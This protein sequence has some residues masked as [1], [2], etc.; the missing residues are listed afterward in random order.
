MSLLSENS[1]DLP[2]PMI[3]INLDR[4]SERFKTFLAR[5]G[6]IGN[7]I[8]HSAT[9]GHAL[10]RAALQRTGYISEN[11]SYGNGTLACALSHIHL[12]ERV[13]AT[14]TP[15]TIFEDDAVLS[16]RFQQLSC[17]IIEK[18]PTNWDIIHWGNSIRPSFVWVDLAQTASRIEP[19][20]PSR[21]TNRDA[22][23]DVFQKLPFVPGALRLLH[24]FGKPGYSL[25]PEGAKKMLRHC[26][27]LTDRWVTFE[28]ARVKVENT[29][30]DIILCDWY[31][32]A[33]AY[34]CVPP[35][36]MQDQRTPS[37]RLA[38]DKD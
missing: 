38:T 19:Y 12:W 4:D 31:P 32:K 20:G 27:P 36:V 9:D 34:T 1:P 16:N 25:S 10:D 3:V 29:A 24:A 37:T 35:I 22:F 5:N 18:L 13:A 7:F 2:F 15:M 8:R 6:H 30:S 21:D 26:L 11:L 28:H 23:F 14:N 17:N 33:Q